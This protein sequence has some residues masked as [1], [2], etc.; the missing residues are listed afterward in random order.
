MAWLKY[1]ASYAHGHG[2]AEYVEFNLDDE[3]EYM[4]DEIRGTLIR[5][6][7]FEILDQLPVEVLAAKVRHAHAMMSS[8]LNQHNRLNKQLTK[9]LTSDS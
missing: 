3:A 2:P 1:Q 6:P 7:K 8:W 9:Q 5:E 4:K